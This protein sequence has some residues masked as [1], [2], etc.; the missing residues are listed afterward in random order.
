MLITKLVEEMKY[1]QPLSSSTW[2]CL[3]LPFLRGFRADRRNSSYGT[4]ILIILE[5]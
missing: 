4:S 1:N 2:F 5:H 3:L